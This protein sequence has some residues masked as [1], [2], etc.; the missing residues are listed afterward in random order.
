MEPLRLDD[1]SSLPS[2]L[3]ARVCQFD[4]L[5]RQ[6]EHID[7]VAADARFRL[8][9]DELEAHLRTQPIRG[10]HC[11]REP[12]PGYYLR[13]GLRLTDV[14][15][16]QAEFMARHG[17]LFTATEAADMKAAWQ[18]YFVGTGQSESR[19]GRL[20]FCLT[21]AT[22]RSS[23]TEVFFNRFGGEAVFMPLKD[24]RTIALK[25][26]QI[27][28]PVIVEVRLPPGAA[29]RYRSL[30]LPLLSAYHLT[31]RPDAHP[32][33]AETYIQQPVPPAD[34]LAVTPV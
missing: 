5:F 4:G 21:E 24:H 13:E 3:L 17:H 20:W 23:G 8:L 30:A 11:S 10:Y 31:V 6:H 32:W 27:G 14:A 12:E 16:H 29:A 7:S 2:D 1:V 33:E 25:L 28:A 22:A 19:N 18:S 15:A 9:R 34:V 26:G